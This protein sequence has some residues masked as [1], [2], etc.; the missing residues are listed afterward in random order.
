MNRLLFSFAASLLMAT[1]AAAQP[2]MHAASGGCPLHLTTLNLSPDQQTKLD[3]IRATHMSEMKIL[4]DSQRTEAAMKASMQRAV[5]GV[6]AILT[7]EQL[8]TFDAAVAEHERHEKMHPAGSTAC[9][10][11]CCAAA[12]T[13]RSEPAKP[14]PPLE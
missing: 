5:A 8:R 7:A 10:C 1:A 4:P 6:R 3:S 13:S 12:A 2:A 9:A 11:A 14:K